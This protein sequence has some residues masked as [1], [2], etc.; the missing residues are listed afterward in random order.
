MWL[1]DK[2][3]EY[4][5]YRHSSRAKRWLDDRSYELVVEKTLWAK[6]TWTLLGYA[7]G[8]ASAILLR[9]LGWISIGT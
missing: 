9:V 2:A 6:V 4:A 3:F 5:R 1:C 7:L 8:F